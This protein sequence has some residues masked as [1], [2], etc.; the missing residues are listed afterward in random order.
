M[1]LKNIS[2]YLRGSIIRLSQYLGMWMYLSFYNF[3]LNGESDENSRKFEKIRPQ[4]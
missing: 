1:K 2:T 3:F 4:S